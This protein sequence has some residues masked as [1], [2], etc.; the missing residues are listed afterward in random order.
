MPFRRSRLLTIALLILLL[1]GTMGIVYSISS[2]T[3]AALKGSLQEKLISAAGITANG[4]DGDALGALRPGDEGT[5]AFTRI[6]DQLHRAK[7]VSPGIH[8]IYTMRMNGNAV[9][10]VVDGDYGYRSDAAGIGVPY[11]PVPAEL[12]AG[13]SGPSADNNFVTDKW[14]ST[15]S[16]YYPVRDSTGAVIGIVGVDM[17]SSDVRAH[18]ERIDLIL[19]VVGIVALFIVGGGIVLVE[20]QRFKSER[21]LQES[22]AKF[23]ALFE[24]AGTAIVIMDQDRV[25]ECNHQTALLFGRSREDIIGRPAGDLAPE[26][27]SDGSPS[28]AK[29]REYME[30]ARSGEPQV[31]EWICTRFDGTLF[32]AEVSLTR[33]ML[34]DRYVVQAVIQDV[35]ERRTAEAALRTVTKKLSLLHAITSTEIQNAVFALSGYLTLEKAEGDQK[36]VTKYWDIEE[37]L[38]KKITRS[39]EFAKSFQDLGASPARWQNVDRVFILA[40]SHLDFTPI[41]RSVRLDNLEIYADPLLERVFFALADN[42][43]RHAK[44]ATQVTLRFE[45]RA[46]DLLIVFEDDGSGIAPDLKERIFEWG[47]GKS[48]HGMS[49]FL[50]REIL[51]ITGISLAETGEPGKG[52]R[53]EM[54]VPEGAFRFAGP[55][56]ADGTD[57]GDPV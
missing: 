21:V 27:Q 43:L 7:E 44:G 54:I 47:V 33:I 31:F 1:L 5:V 30:K 32:M 11:A 29:A 20:R 16:G 52:A 24:N 37:D 39:L 53:F 8:Y 42:V 4:I 56:S 10:F 25:V 26:Y 13:F 38:V 51:G 9:E 41:R 23:K 40:I 46:D 22:E 57:R 19:Y 48:G 2:E 55:G 14:G 18:F 17:D 36:A 35:S 6:R 15:F 28:L 45:P 34:L 12:L 50:A 49:L 3:Q